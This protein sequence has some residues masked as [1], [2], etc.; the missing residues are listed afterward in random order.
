MSQKLPICF[1]LSFNLGHLKP[2]MNE[3]SS[4]N[5]T[6]CPVS[7]KK[8]YVSIIFADLTFATLFTLFFPITSTM[9]TLPSDPDNQPNI[10]VP[11][12]FNDNAIEPHSLLPRVDLSAFADAASYHDI[13]GTGGVPHPLHFNPIQASMTPSTAISPQ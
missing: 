11:P 7:K 13:Q 5:C 4:P 9:A 10:A 3:E 1:P 8:D 12:N 6:T 2:P